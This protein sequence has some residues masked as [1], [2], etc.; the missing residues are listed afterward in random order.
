M[1]FEQ[2][3]NKAEQVQATMKQTHRPP[4]MVNQNRKPS[5]PNRQWS[6]GKPM[7]FI[8]SDFKFSNE[9]KKIAAPAAKA[10]GGPGG[11][12]GNFPNARKRKDDM[13]H[14]L[15]F[16]EREKLKQEGKCYHCKQTSH[17]ASQCPQKKPMTSSYQKINNQQYQSRNRNLKIKTAAL[18]IETQSALMQVMK[19]PTQSR[20]FIIPEARKETMSAEITI[21]G[22][23]V[24]VL[25]D[26]CTQ[27]GDL[28]S[29]N[30]CTQFKLPLTQMEKKP[31]ET[32]IQGSR[33]P[34]TNKRTVVI[35]VQGYEEERTF[36]AGNLRN[37]D[38]ILGEPDIKETKS[39]NEYP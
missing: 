30:F 20:T 33:S 8:K 37:W 4:P 13:A 21:N 12:Y 2:I 16:G 24:H 18:N 5:T 34:M 6:T 28:I 27:G 39:N 36:Y 25:L 19:G 11:L 3:V 29:N 1:S 7:E 32:A 17:M 15:S 35:N 14:V 10:K 23:K 9:K 26:P 38:A 31:L 22:Y